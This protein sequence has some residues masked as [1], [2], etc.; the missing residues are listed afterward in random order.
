[1]GPDDCCTERY[2]KCYMASRGANWTPSNGKHKSLGNIVPRAEAEEE[3][4]SPLMKAEELWRNMHHIGNFKSAEKEKKMVKV[5]LPRN[6]NDNER[7]AQEAAS[8]Q[9]PCKQSRPDILS[10]NS[11]SKENKEE[12]LMMERARL[13]S[14]KAG[15]LGL[16]KQKSTVLVRERRSK[17][18]KNQLFTARKMK[19]E[20]DNIINR[21]NKQLALRTETRQLK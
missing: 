15:G 6:F 11:E 2:P 21:R 16:L 13:R 8:S 20:I 18:E 3:L 7:G 10:F 1:M 4:K 19:T 12:R 17:I 14:E 9:N 5:N